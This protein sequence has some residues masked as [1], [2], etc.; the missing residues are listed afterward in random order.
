MCAPV[1]TE[2]KQNPHLPHLSNDVHQLVLKQ[3]E[4]GL[5]WLV[6]SWKKTVMVVCPPNSL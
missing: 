4:Q 6:A 5:F 2:L 3:Q 1:E